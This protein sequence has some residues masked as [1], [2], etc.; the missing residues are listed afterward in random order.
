MLLAF[1]LFVSSLLVAG[2]QVRSA[3]PPSEVIYQ[4]PDNTTWIENIAVRSNGELLLNVFS[5]G[6]LYSLDPATRTPTIVH[7]FGAASLFG[8]TEVTPDVFAVVASTTVWKVDFNQS[9]PVVSSVATITG[10]SFLN[11]IT[12]IP[13]TSIV[14][15]ADSIAGVVYKLNIDD[16]SFSAA[17]Q[18]PEM[19]DPS[20]GGSFSVGVNGVLVHDGYLYW[21]NSN[22]E[23]LYR[24]RID[25]A[26]EAAE[27]TVVELVADV[28]AL[29]DDFDFDDAG[30]LWVTTT[31]DNLLLMISPEGSVV[32]AVGGDGV[33][34]VAGGTSCAFGRR[35]D[36]TWM[37]YVVTNTGK[38]V[39]VNTAVD[40]AC[41]V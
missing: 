24:V 10:T 12:Q 27:S 9:P 36:D 19:S 40:G 39:A 4:F 32:T 17:F 11:G 18:Y 35:A 31:S 37:L 38:V 14:F 13:G 20:T 33:D 26:G 21:S 1:Q 30:N 3:P 29:A 5:T 25:E 8:I 23:A 22:G 15:I 16:Q 6:T 2:F 28:M 7:N 41:G 34:T